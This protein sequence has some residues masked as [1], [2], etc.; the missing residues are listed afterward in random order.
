MLK[1][2]SRKTRPSEVET[3]RRRL[4]E[5]EDALR[6]IKSGQVDALVVAGPEG[7]QVF[8]LNDANRPYRHL[9]EQM[10]EGACILSPQGTVL[11]ANSYLVHLLGVRL[12]QLMG[13]PWPHWVRAE[14]QSR[15]GRL[16]QQSLECGAKSEIELASATG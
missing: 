5:A 3:L 12:E 9:A 13:L 1:T 4:E 2:N 10:Q 8:T 16:L 6:A 15:L 14:D 11:F 7:D